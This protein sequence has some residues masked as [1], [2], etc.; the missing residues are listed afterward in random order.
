MKACRD[1]RY[2]SKTGRVCE[3]PRSFVELADYYTGQMKTVART[4]DIMRMTM[5]G[6]CG[7]DAVLFEPREE[8]R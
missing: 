5:L 4:I 3:H 7:N 1:C 2:I 6:Q 8:S